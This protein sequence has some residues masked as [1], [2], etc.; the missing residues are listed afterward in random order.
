MPNLDGGHYFLSTLIPVRMQPLQRADG[1]FTTPSHVLREALASLPTAQ[2]SPASVAC[3]LNSPFARCKRTHFVRAVVIDQ[4]MF[5]GRDAGNALLQA[6]RRV[7][8]LAHPPVDTL[9]CPYLMFNA[10]FD[11]VPTEPDGGLAS[12]AA[13]LWQRAEPEM[14][15]LFEAGVGF[16]AVSSGE[17]F[18]VWLKRCQLATTMSFCDY[19]VPTPALQGYT[20]KRVGLAIALGSAAL[21]ALLVAALLALRCSLWWLLAGVPLAVVISVVVA[22]GLL[23]RRGSQPFP[24]SANTQLPAILKALLVQQRFAALATE[25]QGADAATVHRRF[26]EF[27]QTVQPADLSGLSQS[28]GVIRSDGLPLMSVPGLAPSAVAP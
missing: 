8:L 5:N 4:P 6:L 14:R 20:L 11:A 23:W 22:L 18:A 24:A 10:E 2:Q 12:W 1:S 3:G 25:L 26:A 13:G 16:D 15:A 28:P 19:N 7:N 9:R 17:A 27:V 21:S